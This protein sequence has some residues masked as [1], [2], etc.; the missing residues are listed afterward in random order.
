MR[1]R[2]A[3]E[4]AGSRKEGATQTIYGTSENSRNGAP[5][6]CL[7]EWTVDRQRTVVPAE[8]APH[9]VGRSIN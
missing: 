9:L 8:D 6:G 2:G 5:T 3:A 1:Q 4:S 7:R